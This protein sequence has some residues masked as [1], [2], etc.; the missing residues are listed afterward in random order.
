MIINNIL[1]FSALL[2]LTAFGPIQALT[3][4][5]LNQ[6]PVFDNFGSFDAN[7]SESPQ[8]YISIPDD[9]T[10]SGSTALS[11]GCWAK[12]QFQDRAGII[13]QWGET[14]RQFLLS[15]GRTAVGSGD[16][17]LVTVCGNA[18][19]TSNKQYEAAGGLFPVSGEDWVHV[20]FTWDNGTLLLYANGSSQTPSII[21]D[22]SFTTLND[23]PEDL[24]IG[25]R[26][27]FSGFDFN[28]K[29]DECF[30]VK[31]VLTSQD[32]SDI[33]D[34]GNPTDLSSYSMAGWWRFE[35]DSHHSNVGGIIDASGTG[36][37]GTG[38]NLVAADINN[39]D[40]P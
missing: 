31:S 20:G 38:Q 28:G 6:G 40:A 21:N 2:V 25:D 8:K 11:V 35:S 30:I 17:M 1:L 4:G 39:P 19:C 33:Y 5:L 7:I 24:L 15:T 23:S 29:I 32:F 36:N 27:F 12:G 37:H 34:G 26:A 18:D 13:G 10:I 16:L 3:G 22:N 14:N 9:P